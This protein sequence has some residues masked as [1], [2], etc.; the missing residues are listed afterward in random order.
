MKLSNVIVLFILCLNIFSCKKKE[1]TMP[2]PV[3]T[4][5]ISKPGNSISATPDQNILFEFTCNAVTKPDKLVGIS[6]VNGVMNT[7]RE[8]LNKGMSST[9]SVDN[10]TDTRTIKNIVESNVLL[11]AGDKVELTY[12]FYDKNGQTATTKI[13]VTII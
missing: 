3:P 11:K 5:T 10:Y 6:E 12:T 9:T 1:E 8:F 4:I 7:R 13:Q 2:T